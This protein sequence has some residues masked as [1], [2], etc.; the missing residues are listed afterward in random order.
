MFPEGRSVQPNGMDHKV[1]P[2]QTQVGSGGRKR[3]WELGEASE[4]SPWPPS[5]R[6]GGEPPATLTE[7][8]LGA[9]GGSRE[10][11]QASPSELERSCPTRQADNGR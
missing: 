3:G 2:G 4:W 8:G 7:A 11:G 1:L 9:E 10:R 6:E 5:S